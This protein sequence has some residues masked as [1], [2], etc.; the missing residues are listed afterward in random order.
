MASERCK[1]GTHFPSLAH[2]SLISIK[3]LCDA[4]CKVIYN[5]DECHI[6][7]DNKFVWLGKREPN[8]GLWILPLTDATQRPPSTTYDCNYNIIANHPPKNYTHN[9]Y[10]MTS[11]ASLI[12]YLHQAAFSPPKAPL[13]KA[14]NNNQFSTW[15]GFTAKVDQKYLPEL[16]PAMDKGHMKR[17]KK[18]IRSTKATIMT[19]L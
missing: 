4:G 19:A 3:V 6:Y 11:K 10:D 8:T 12:N 16:I 17:Q 18:G 7:Y 2:A 13:F 1:G 15:S 5:E 14:L 9:A